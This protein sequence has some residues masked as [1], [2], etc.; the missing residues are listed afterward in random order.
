MVI[1]PSI[2]VARQT[3][4]S[5]ASRPFKL[6]EETAGEAGHEAR[7]AVTNYVCLEA[8]QR[9]FG[10]EGKDARGVSPLYRAGPQ[11]SEQIRA[12]QPVTIAETES[13]L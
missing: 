3:T 12:F 8:P 1:W 10:F 2:V 11:C 13:H 9:C 5:L 7:T 4:G 6:E